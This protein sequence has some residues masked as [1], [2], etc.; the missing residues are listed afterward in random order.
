MD[1]K[2]KIKEVLENG[3]LMSL[4]TLDDSGVW[5]SDLIYI[6]DDNF[7]IY[8]MSDPDVRHSQ[9]ILKNKQI[10]GTITISNKNK[11]NNLGIQ[12]N[13][14]A[15]KIEGVRYDLAT[16]HFLKRGNLLPKE[17]NDVL[18]GDSWYVLRLAKIELIDE[19]NFGF[20]KKFLNISL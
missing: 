6:Y 9:A 3:Y 12:F 19:K 5:V 2:T 13:G 17:E 15:E 18:Q 16:K 20:E 10:A 8:W 4:A 7:N 11:E 14:I 1:I